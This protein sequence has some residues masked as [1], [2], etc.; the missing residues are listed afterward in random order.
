M[1]RSSGGG[2]TAKAEAV[3]PWAEHAS[4]VDP[5]VTAAEAAVRFAG[6]LQ[7]RVFPPGFE[8]SLI[9]QAKEADVDFLDDWKSCFQVGDRVSEGA[10]KRLRGALSP[11]KACLW[12]RA[13]GRSGRKVD[14]TRSPA[15][16][17]LHT[18]LPARSLLLI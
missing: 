9:W 7:M 1:L 18:P 6:S 13:W 15:L 12:S 17:A 11:R 5:P 8:N 3:V 16:S 10:S 4:F 14:V 2:P